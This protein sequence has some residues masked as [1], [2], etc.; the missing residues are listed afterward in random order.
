MCRHS[1]PR[2]FFCK[3]G[4]EIHPFQAPILCLAW[5]PAHS[6]H[7][8]NISAFFLPLIKH[9]TWEEGRGKAQGVRNWFRRFGVLPSSDLPFHGCFLFCVSSCSR[10]LVQHFPCLRGPCLDGGSCGPVCAGGSQGQ[11]VGTNQ[12]GCHLSHTRL[13]ATA[14]Q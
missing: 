11:S 8:M 1:E 12:I 3:M 13:E 4:K 7:F 14:P 6:G 10:S 2:F 9:T 5:P